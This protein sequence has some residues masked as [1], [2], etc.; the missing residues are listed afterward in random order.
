MSDDATPLSVALAP[1]ALTLHWPDSKSTIAADVLRV[2][3]RCAPCESARRRGEPVASEGVR[4]V[5]ARHVGHYALQLVFSDGHER[6]IY[7]FAHARS[8][9]G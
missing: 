5:D 3:C 2:N 1:D 7:P 4:L 8:L 6:G 9:A